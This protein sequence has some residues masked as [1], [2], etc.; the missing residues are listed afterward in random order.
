MSDEKLRE[1]VKNALDDWYGEGD[2]SELVENILAVL[3]AHPSL[4]PQGPSGT[5]EGPQHVGGDRKEKS[6]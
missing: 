1:R 3:A 2:R 6:K 4:P 5:T